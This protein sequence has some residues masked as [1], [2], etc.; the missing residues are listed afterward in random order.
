MQVKRRGRCVRVI[1]RVSLRVDVSA[2]TLAREAASVSISESFSPQSAHKTVSGSSCVLELPE[3]IGGP[4]RTRT[5]DP[6]IKSQLLY[7]LS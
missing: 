7:Q 6:L 2:P 3:R 4:S 1:S 5:L